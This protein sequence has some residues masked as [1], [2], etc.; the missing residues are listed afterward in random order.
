MARTPHSPD[1]SPDAQAVGKGGLGGTGKPLRA[2]VAYGP[3]WEP[4]DEVRYVGNRSSG[5]MGCAI[6]EAFTARQC[7]VTAAIGPDCPTPKG[8]TR[9]VA[10]ESAASLMALLLAEWPAHDLLVM[11]AA[12]ADFRPARP[13]AGKLRRESGAFDLALEPT[14]DILAGLA[15]HTRPDQF[16][17]GFALER[18]AE[19]ED[20]AAAKLARKRVDAIVA[21]PL[22]TMGA[23]SVQGRVLLASGGWVAPEE[24]RSLPKERFAAWLADL[25]VPLAVARVRGTGP[26]PTAAHPDPRR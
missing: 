19:L 2:L 14:E 7:A 24:G 26:S 13:V 21:N 1:G 8:A 17:V 18:P 3:T 5:R 25:V 15:N 4:L 23:P 16:V 20:S 11:A 10:F 9:V 22:E 12:V 6:A